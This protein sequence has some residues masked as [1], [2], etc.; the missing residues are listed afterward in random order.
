ME[1]QVLGVTC[2]QPLLGMR[3]LQTFTQKPVVVWYCIAAATQTFPS[4]FGMPRG[5]LVRHALRESAVG[6]STGTC[7]MKSLPRRE[8]RLTRPPSR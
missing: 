3:S 6:C 1:A 2:S 7:R 8:I 4:G 5:I